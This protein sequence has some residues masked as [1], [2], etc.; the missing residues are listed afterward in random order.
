M[1]DR[2]PDPDKRYGLGLTEEAVRCL[3]DILRR[4]G[5]TDVTLEQA[6]ARAIEL[7][8]LFRMFLTASAREHDKTVTKR[9]RFEHPRR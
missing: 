3:Q 8:S 2:V 6:W 9:A 4:E 1:D 7:I 5:D